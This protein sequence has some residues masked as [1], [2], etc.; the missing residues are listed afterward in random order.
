MSALRRTCHPA[1][2]ATRPRGG[3]LGAR[4]PGGMLGARQPGGMLGARRACRGREHVR[5]IGWHT[6]PK[7]GHV[8]PPLACP[9]W[10]KHVRLTPDMPPGRLGESMSALRRTC[11]PAGCANR[12]EWDAAQ[13]DNARTALT[14]RRLQ[15]ARPQSRLGANRNRNAA[16]AKARGSGL[17]GEFSAVILVHQAVQPSLSLWVEPT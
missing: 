10:R 12:P 3:M 11:H 17:F 8:L 6:R 15:P 13:N 1:G 7:G 2:H 4:Q 5:P 9:P 16:R 14:S